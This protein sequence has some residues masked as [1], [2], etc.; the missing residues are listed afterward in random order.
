MTGSEVTGRNPPPEKAGVERVVHTGCTD[1]WQET[2]ERSAR[3]IARQ[4]DQNVVLNPSTVR[5]GDPRKE[6]IE[7]R[8]DGGHAR[9]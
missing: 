9:R 1:F 4:D 7:R 5:V 2:P 3:A 8:R 6:L